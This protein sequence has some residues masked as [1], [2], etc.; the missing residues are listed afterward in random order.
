MNDRTRTLLAVFAVVSIFLG[1][2]LGALALVEPFE[3]SHGPAVDNPDDP[4]NSAVFFGV[5]LV[6]TAVMLAAFKY[7][8]ERFIRWLI[9]GVS[10]MLSWF[11]FAE[12][13][14]DL[15]VVDGLSV[16]PVA[17]AAVLGA[18]LLAYPEWYVID[19]AGLLMAAGAAA[20]FGI[21][22][23]LLPALVFLVV[24][25]VYDAISVYRTEHMLSLADGALDLKIPVVFVVPTSLSYSYL[26]DDGPL[27]DPE[28]TS[29]EPMADDSET[30][31][32][33]GNGGTSPTDRSAEPHEDE[34]RAR[35]ALFIGL[36]DAVIPTILVA[37]AVSFLEAPA[38]D[39]P[40][41]A[42]TVPALGAILGTISG[43]VV[44]MYMVLQGRPHAGLPL[45]NGGA[46]SG[47]LLGALA[48]GISITTALG[49]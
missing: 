40:L 9:V 33:T 20:L 14:P 34:K 31:S 12:L 41:I 43:L 26:D 48:S 27:D 38:I 49:L 25:A 30:E 23:G 2:Q 46:I 10:V 4:T 15:L 11:V 45:L 13:F 21:S 7:D 16:L 44:L 35:D 19:A 42:L 47:Y 3:Q 17:A 6:A 37:S 18:G 1:V 5:I 32:A 39:V 28:P 36:G 22:F 8:A 24:L 29:G